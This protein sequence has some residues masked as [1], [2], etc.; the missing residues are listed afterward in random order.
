MKSTEKESKNV[1][2]TTW[3]KLESKLLT[4]TPRE[5]VKKN[6]RPSTGR[7][8]R[9]R[10]LSQDVP[11]S[12]C[13]TI[14]NSRKDLSSTSFF[15]ALN[16]KNSS[17]FHSMSNV[18]FSIIP[19]LS[20]AEVKQIYE[21]KCQDLGIQP[22][23][24]QEKRFTSYCL[25][26]FYNRTFDMME[27]GLGEESA[28][29]IGSIL[30][31]SQNFAFLCLGKNNLGDKGC[32]ELLK[33][34]YK[35]QNI[36][37]IDFSSNEL[38]CV[39]VKDLSE[40]FSRNEALISIDI[41][42]HK[43]LNRNRI[44]PKGAES[45]GKVLQSCSILQF[46]NLAGTGIGTE[47]LKYL[48]PGIAKSKN[49][50][51]LNL[52]SNA[53]SWEKL[54]ELGR[55]VL[56]SN[57][58]KLELSNNKLGYEGALAVAE[59]LMGHD[60]MACT[61]EHLDLSCNLI[62]TKGLSK[63]LY[64]LTNNQTLRFLNLNE[65]EFAAGLSTN[66]PLFFIE[67]SGIE[68]LYLANC[69]I[70]SQALINSFPEAFPKNRTIKEIDLSKN[71]ICDV[72]AEA[73]CIGLS[74]N[75]GLKKLNLCANFIKEKGG[76]AFAN[77]L[78]MNT[79]LEELNLKEN[80]INDNAGQL[81]D[82]ICRKNR[83]IMD[84]NLNLNSVALN[85]VF[86]IKHN[87]KKNKK[88]KKKKVVPELKGKIRNL[89]QNSELLDK[90]KTKLKTKQSEFSEL[91]KRVERNSDRLSA[92]SQEEADKNKVVHDEYLKVKH[93]NQEVSKEFEELLYEI[94]VKFI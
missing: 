65:N 43:G 24:E 82:N 83:N 2:E 6:T 48:I 66:F 5:S 86:N 57:I 12:L 87:L 14:R 70:K 60:N 32:V 36:V 11:S 45:M 93:R 29:V 18:S 52:S 26:H 44:G 91:N 85:F 37:H 23:P 55:S 28:K 73:I 61:V 54:R 16:S 25:H 42:S 30:Q 13:E 59:M 94:A 51:S 69:G 53:L 90:V 84:I 20:P 3:T 7:I 22:F 39:G 27:S 1:L 38:T 72:G 49:L 88:E 41:S 10:N 19:E 77:C 21:A 46:L 40:Y 78:K 80:N 34:I 62:M 64:S 15:H 67:N 68:V 76:R 92:I 75:L 8:N 74:R 50:L 89:S 47:G 81:L 79:A 58:I 33:S 63:I 56:S 9:H 71:K 35:N 31:T 4:F 17:N